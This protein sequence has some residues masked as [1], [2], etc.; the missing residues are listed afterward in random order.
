MTSPLLTGPIA[1]T[2]TI[3]CSTQAE[4]LQAQE[5]IGRVTA[6][7]AMDGMY[8]RTDM[9]IVDVRDYCEDA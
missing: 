7:L 5:A 9:S 4:G 1:L 8:V 6:G 2:V 3:L